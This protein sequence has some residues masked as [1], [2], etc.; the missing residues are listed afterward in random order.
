[1]KSKS[2]KTIFSMLFILMLL[3]GSFSVSFA[4]A[5]WGYTYKVLDYWCVDSGKHLD[6]SGT[7]IYIS[8]FETAV[9]TWNNYKNGVIRKDTLTTVNDVT[10]EDVES[11]SG[12]TVAT[13]TTTHLGSGKGTG[14]IKFSTTN[15][16]SLPTLRRTIA[17]THELGHALGLDE[18][19]NEGTDVIM[20]NDMSTNS[21]NN[22]L[23]Q[24]DKTNYDYMY[25]NKY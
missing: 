1:M 9:D 12:N 3:G 16:N 14:V 17:C 20:Y 11:I 22:V 8:N 2:K 10:I 6:W 4:A 5:R 13:T 15:M 18:N 19:N 24:A 25:D 7:T 21:S 23:H